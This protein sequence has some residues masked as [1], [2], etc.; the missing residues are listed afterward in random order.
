[1]QVILLQVKGTGSV[2][3]AVWVGFGSCL[4]QP[5]TACYKEKQI[6]LENA[7]LPFLLEASTSSGVAIRRAAPAWPLFPRPRT[8]HTYMPTYM[9]TQGSRILET[10]HQL[11][12]F[13]F[14]H[15]LRPLTPS[16]SKQCNYIKICNGEVH[17]CHSKETLRAY[18]APGI[19][20]GHEDT[21]MKC[22]VLV[23]KPHTTPGGQIPLWTDTRHSAQSPS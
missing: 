11:I 17:T 10:Q 3:G 12:F 14:R 19:L 1:M 9:L 2:G 6:W 22:P 8:S 20:L 5:S 7:A 15:A 4:W 23:I 18:C 13:I 21:E 16:N